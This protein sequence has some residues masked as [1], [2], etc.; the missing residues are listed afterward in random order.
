MMVK[1]GGLGEFHPM[2]PEPT[3]RIRLE[4]REQSLEPELRCQDT[5]V[6]PSSH[7]VFFLALLP[8][9]GRLIYSPLFNMQQIFAEPQ[10]LS[11]P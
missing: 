6:F 5:V 8:L 3:W 1:G 4:V 2:G 11:K 10:K 7:L 9:G